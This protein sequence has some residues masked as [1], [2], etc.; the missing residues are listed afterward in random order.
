[1]GVLTYRRHGEQGIAEVPPGHCLAGHPL[2]HP[3]VLV[4]WDGK[5][6]TYTCWACSQERVEVHT[7]R[8]QTVSQVLGRAPRSWQEVMEVSAQAGRRS[9]R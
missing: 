2:R 5:G 1:M 4:G 8:Y 3:N 7:L 6:R 9:S